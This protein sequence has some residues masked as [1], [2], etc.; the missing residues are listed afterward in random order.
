MRVAADCPVCGHDTGKG[1]PIW[2]GGYIIGMGITCEEC[3]SVSVL[4]V[5]IPST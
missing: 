5:E 3:G 4:T 1:E 2:S